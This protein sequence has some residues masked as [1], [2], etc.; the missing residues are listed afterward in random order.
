MT[1]TLRSTCEVTIR[2]NE[3][4]PMGIVWHGH[5]IQYFEDGREAFG[6]EHGI[7]YSQVHE[8]GFTIPIVNISC[9]YKRSLKYGEKAIVETTYQDCNAAKIE[10]EYKIF[11]SSDG[12]LAATGKSTQV[13]LNSTGELQLII[14]GFVTEWKKKKGIA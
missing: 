9:E 1:S 11:R 6:K 8:H 4:D 14:P 5:Y 10:F 13:F 12:Q 2:F 7:S 3:A